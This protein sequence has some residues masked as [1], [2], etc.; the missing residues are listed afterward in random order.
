MMQSSAL[1]SKN[2]EEIPGEIGRLSS[3]IRA[4]RAICRKRYVRSLLRNIKVHQISQ[5]VEMTLQ[6]ML[7][8]F[9]HFAWKGAPNKG[10]VYLV[11]S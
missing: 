9:R 5:G 3:S 1:S 10:D 7:N 11:F 8:C 2:F 4:L 6:I